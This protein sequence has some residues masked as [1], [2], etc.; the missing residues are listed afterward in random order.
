MKTKTKRLLIG[1]TLSLVLSCVA[2]FCFLLL[3]HIF[4]QTDQRM[5]LCILCDGFFVVGFLG[6]SVGALVIITST[7]FFDILAYGVKNMGLLLIAR[8][9][10][11]FEKYYD[12]VERRRQIREQRQQYSELF[13][14]LVVGLLFIGIS[15]FFLIFIY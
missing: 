1:Y 12:F 14:P 5:I 3:K 9:K 11:D 7:G 13:I 4:S 2:V 6:A 8:G 15:A 10:R